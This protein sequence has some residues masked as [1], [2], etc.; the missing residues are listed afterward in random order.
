MTG[1]KAVAMLWMIQVTY[2]SVSKGVLHA[3]TI[4]TIKYGLKT[5]EKSLI[6]TEIFYK[7]IS[8]IFLSTKLRLDCWVVCEKIFLNI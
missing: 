7:V 4:K 3:K 1:L 8:K 6:I 2:S 5:T